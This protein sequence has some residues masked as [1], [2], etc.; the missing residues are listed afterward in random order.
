MA[1]NQLGSKE[2]EVGREERGRLTPSLRLYLFEEAL[3]MLVNVLVGIDLVE[4]LGNG[5]YRCRLD[6]VVVRGRF[7]LFKHLHSEHQNLVNDVRGL[8]KSVVG[9]EVVA[10]EGSE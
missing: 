6:G 1:I 8:V 10:D 2:G 7:G 9:A 4:E 3:D 5:E